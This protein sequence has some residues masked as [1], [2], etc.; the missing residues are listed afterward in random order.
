MSDIT[1]PNAVRFA[2]EQIRTFADKVPA[3]YAFLKH[4]TLLWSD[5]PGLADAFPDDPTAIVL[6]GSQDDGRRPISGADVRAFESLIAGFVAQLEADDR[7]ALKL[8]LKIAVNPA[9]TGI[10]TV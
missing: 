3:I 6:D 9:V 10:S 4:H 5:T 7:A 2:N 1:E 8:T